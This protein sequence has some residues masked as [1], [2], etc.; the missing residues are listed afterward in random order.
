MTRIFLLSVSLWLLTA[1]SDQHDAPETNSLTGSTKEQTGTVVE[2]DISPDEVEG[3]EPIIEYIWHKAGPK[4]SEE[5]LAEA[6]NTW[7]G[8][9][10]DGPYEITFAN[11]LTPHADN[12]DYDFVWAILWES[13]EA[14]QAGW[15]YWKNNQEAEWRAATSQLLSY[16]E[17]GAYSISPTIQR[18]PSVE[19]DSP[20]FEIQFQFCNYGE[21]VTAEQYAAFQAEYETWLDAFELTNGPMGYW[22]VA[23]E[24]QFEMEDPNNFV[25]LHIWPNAEDKA[26]GMT[27]WA[28]S[29]LF[30]QWQSLATCELV[31]FSGKRIRSS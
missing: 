16:S 20:D 19:S 1:C 8:L 23:L 13:M 7:N 4:F 29:P 30:D 25:W 11:I 18:P 14:R 31:D 27:A 12:E 21:E 15:N 3:P 26:T 10:N 24:P 6:V 17:E 22:Y 5:A 28:Q 9:I 2:S